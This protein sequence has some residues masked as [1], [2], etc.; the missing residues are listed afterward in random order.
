MVAS[1]Y[2]QLPVE[3]Q[4]RTAILA[5]NYGEAGAIDY[6]GPTYGLP[7]AISPH[8]AYY[9]WGPRG[10]SGDVVIAIGMKVEVL[11][12]L[13]GDVQQAAT[14]TNS[15]AMPSESNLAIYVCRKPFKTLTEA[16]PQLKSLI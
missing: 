13:F 2:R 11:Q 12:S 8:N 7:R 9:L 4:K 16:W 14:I 6:F 1:V 15:D 10:Q 5:G 3:D